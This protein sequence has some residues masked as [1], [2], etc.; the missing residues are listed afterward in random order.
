MGIFSQPFFML[1]LAISLLAGGATAGGWTVRKITVERYESQMLKMQ[2]DT[3][4]R[5][6][7]KEAEFND[8]SGKYENEKNS[9][10]VVTKIINRSFDR[11]VDRPVYRD[12]QC[13]DADGLRIVNAAIDGTAAS[14]GQLD[15]AMHAIDAANQN[16]G[17]GSSTKNH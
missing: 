15:A 16:I 9:R 7:A 6:A 2:S 4:K 10:H 3:Q 17:G 8:I 14:A 13:I 5:Y 11:I 1:S 12:S